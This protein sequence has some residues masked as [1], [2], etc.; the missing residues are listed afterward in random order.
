MDGTNETDISGASGSSYMLAE[1]D[2]GKTIKVRVSFT[3]DAGNAETVTSAVTATVEATVPGTPSSVEANPAGT[4][5]IEVSWEQPNS[6]GGSAI[7]G[8]T[9]HWKETGDSWENAEDVSEADTRDTSYTITSLS[10]GTEYTVRVTATNSVG[11][12]PTSAEEKATADAQT[13]GQQERAENTPATGD[14]TISGTLEVGQTLTASTSGISDADGLANATFSYQ[15]IANN[16]TADT[17][18]QD[19]TAS[20]YTLADADEGK[21]IKVRVSFTDEAG[22]SEMLIS[23]ATGTVEAA[24]NPATGQPS[25]SGTA[26][27]AETLTAGTSSIADTDGTANATVTYQWIRMDGTNETDIA[28]A[29]SSSYT[30]TEADEGKAIKVRVSFADDAGNAE[31]LTSAATATVE[32]EAQAEN[33][34]ATGQP[35]IGGTAQVGETLTAG[36]TAIADSD[37]TDNAV[38]TYQWLRLDGVSESNISGA[39]G[40]SY[41]L[42][43]ADEGKTIK[44]RVSLTDDAGNDETM[45]SAATA[46]V[47]PEPLEP[48]AAPQNLTAESNNDGTITL[49]WN[50]PDDDSVTGYQILRR[51]P[52]E[53]ENSLEIYVSDTGSTATE[54]T[55]ADAPA[56]TR[57][58]YRVKAINE[59]GAGGRSNYARVDH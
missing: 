12:G 33:S 10:L 19:A 27:V 39:T 2:Q 54:Y 17:D 31:M 5:E 56:G 23:P 29:T 36:T 58:V 48:P 57:Y 6:N 4:G 34:P 45:T 37:G 42:T 30:L 47:E 46:T 50:A 51:R 43:D 32:A 41:T 8:Y 20:T 40:T 53:G 15:W 55:D 35:T 1:A 18:I 3:D 11:D 9:V 16:G 7:T 28:G 26:Q 24:N 13:S 21:T 59:A 49:T 22:N 52:Q 44:V 25:V 38:F 14:P